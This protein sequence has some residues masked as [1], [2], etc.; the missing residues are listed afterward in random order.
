M[1]IWS[2]YDVPMISRVTRDEVQ[3]ENENNEMA[4]LKCRIHEINCYST[5]TALCNEMYV[6]CIYASGRVK[7]ALLFI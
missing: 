6:V 4:D 3:E 7:V 2:S 1:S 5:K